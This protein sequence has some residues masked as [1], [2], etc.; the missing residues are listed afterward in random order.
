MGTGD[1]R[2][3][4]DLAAREPGTLA[5]GL[6]ANATTMADA[7]RRA[8]RPAHRGGRPNARFVLAAAET[9]PPALLGAADL[10][11][12]RFPW[13]SLLRGVVGLDEAVAAGIA[14]V[15]APRGTLEVLLA[16]SARDHLDG[17]PTETD[18]IVVAATRAFAP[19]G[20]DLAVGRAATAVEVAGSGS[21]WA[22]RLAAGR[23]AST[24]VADH[25]RAVTLVRLVRSGRR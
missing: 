24:S 10:V 19:R 4:L 2:A 11:T 16:P 12:V 25:E 23:K 21:T 13:G 15:V 22:K 9:P 1:G 5:L 17:V 8:A 7:S 18:D 20:F 6:D 14:S 3:V